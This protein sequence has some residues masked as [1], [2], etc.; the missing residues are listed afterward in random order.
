MIS[1]IIVSSV[2]MIWMYE[3]VSLYTTKNALTSEYSIIENDGKI[4]R[5]SELDITYLSL[6][7]QVYENLTREEFVEFTMND[8]KKPLVI[9]GLYREMIYKKGRE[10]ASYLLDLF[11]SAKFPTEVYQDKYE[12]CNA[13]PIMKFYNRYI[14][15]TIKELLDHWMENKLPYLYLAEVDLLDVVESNVNVNKRL[16]IQILITRDVVSVM[17]I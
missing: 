1:K 15:M 7:S 17:M 8:F 2:F 9:K 10:N 14:M 13:L 16:L 11:G 4:C 6:D 3:C 12:F 5:N